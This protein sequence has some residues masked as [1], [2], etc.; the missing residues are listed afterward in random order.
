MSPE[1]LAAAVTPR[2]A[3]IVPVHLYGHPADVPALAEAAPGIPI[4]EDAAQG[5]GAAYHGRPIG[6]AAT[7]ACFSFYPT[8]NL[9]AYGDGGAIVTDDESLAE[10]LRALRD[11][12]R[13]ASRNEHS[14]FGTNARIAELQAAVLRV[15]LDHLP[16]WI[17][18]RRALAA[19][20]D[21]RLGA[22]VERQRVSEWAEHVRHLYVI[23]D[24]RRDQML[25]HLHDCGIG[26]ALHYPIPVHLQEAM[27]GRSWRAVGPLETT[28]R[29][30][31]ECLSLPL[32]PELPPA[33]VD[34]VAD[35]VVELSAREFYVPYGEAN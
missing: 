14:V 8:K 4:V 30:A 27:R 25:Q 1:A 23:L 3:A 12:G 13:A 19:R 10:K 33:S 31:A 11:H 26:A 34:R 15:K 21:D 16:R 6:S 17:E 32:Y 29:L 22:S 24:P 5:H 35:V 18:A 20:Y 28:E 9:G 7:A 2:T